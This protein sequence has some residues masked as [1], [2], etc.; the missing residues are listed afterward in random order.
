MCQ[1]ALK[2]ADKVGHEQRRRRKFTLVLDVMQ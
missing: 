1:N 2:E